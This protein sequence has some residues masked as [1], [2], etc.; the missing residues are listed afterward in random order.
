MTNINTQYSKA[1][2]DF[3]KQQA[4]YKNLLF[5]NNYLKNHLYQ[6]RLEQNALLNKDEELS[7]PAPYEVDTKLLEDLPQMKVYIELELNTIKSRSKSLN[8]AIQD[9]SAENTKLSQECIKLMKENIKIALQDQIA[10]QEKQM[11]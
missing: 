5:R 7:L 1:K 6:L 9:V 4:E 11:Q 3:Y 2:A 8:K 10:I